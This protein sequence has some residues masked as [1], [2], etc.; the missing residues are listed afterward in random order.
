MLIFSNSFKHLGFPISLGT[1]CL[2]TWGEI[3]AEK[4]YIPKVW[5][6]TRQYL[7]CIYCVSDSLGCVF[8]NP[9][10]IIGHYIYKVECG[11]V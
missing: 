10:L 3:I 7:L 2:M 6:A 4:Y 8:N 9:I 11:R 1:K 5:T